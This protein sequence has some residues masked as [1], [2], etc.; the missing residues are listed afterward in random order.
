[1]AERLQNRNIMWASCNGVK[2]TVFG[3]EYVIKVSYGYDNGVRQIQVMADP[4]NKEDIN[5]QNIK[6]KIGED[7]MIDILADDTGFYAAVY[8]E[9]FGEGN[10]EKAQ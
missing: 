8:K 3:K 5:Y 1:M 2:V 10:N 6:A 7:W 9:V 4:I